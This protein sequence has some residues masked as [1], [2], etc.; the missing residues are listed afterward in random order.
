[1]PGRAQKTSRATRHPCSARLCRC[2]CARPKPERAFNLSPKMSRIRKTKA[3]V[4]DQRFGREIAC[5]VPD[6]RGRHLEQ[7]LR[8]AHH[9]EVER[10]GRV[11]A[12]HDHQPERLRLRYPEGHGV[13]DADGLAEEST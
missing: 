8:T 3:A 5:T 11:G 6:G 2:P 7:L 4:S 13:D 9:V 12:R 10:R 1:M